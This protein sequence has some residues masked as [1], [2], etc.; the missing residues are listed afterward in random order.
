M[1]HLVFWQHSLSIH[2]S[3]LLRSL[4]AL[5]DT[6]VTL[7]VE[8]E[9]HPQRR[10]M[11]WYKPD[12]GNTRIVVGPSPQT[13]TELLAE[14]P[15]NTI[16]IFP[17]SRGS[18]QIAWRAFCKS[19]LLA[20]HIGVY[21][22][23]QK[24]MGLKGFFR[25]MRS[26]YDSLRYRERIAFILGIGTLGV[27][28]FQ[29]SGYLH[30]RI[31]PFGYFVE[32]PFTEPLPESRL[33]E[34]YVDLIFVGQ[35]IKRKGWDILLRA[36]SE[37]DNRFWRLHVVGDGVDRDRV[38]G[39]CKKLGLDD[40]VHFYGTLSNSEVLNLISRS[41][42]L[43]LPSRWDGWGAVVNE[44][45]MCGV[46]VVCSDRCGSADLL[47]N[48][49]R[50]E[51]FAV[52]DVSALHSVLARRIAQGKTQAVTRER[53]KE[54]AKCISGESAAAHFWEIANIA[55]AGGTVPVPPWLE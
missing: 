37:L 15:A 51:V 1:K 17:G 2:Q 36:L 3:V 18:G 46:P 5:S 14:D 31:F 42:L 10:E 27:R 29:A 35:L 39:L 30:D 13:Q 22:E 19:P 4:A 20:S 48:G 32:M 9:M 50:G 38:V 16:H 24:H 6:K 44:A 28:W 54:W 23:A 11:G 53:I 52:G 12:F 7:V 33:S 47:D 8:H 45:L 34:N 25:L 55:I 43:V 26:K 40:S 49:E 21:S 41:D